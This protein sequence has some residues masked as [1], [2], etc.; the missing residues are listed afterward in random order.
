M[1]ACATQYKKQ[2]AEAKLKAS[3]ESV[4]SQ[5]GKSKRSKREVKEH[6]E[7]QNCKEA[8]EPAQQDSSMSRN[9]SIAPSRK[10]CKSR[11]K[12]NR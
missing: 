7:P 5:R 3:A 2:K 12:K 4:N 10:R 11:D 1:K 9:H 8:E 6:A